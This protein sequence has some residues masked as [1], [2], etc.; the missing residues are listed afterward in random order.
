MISMEMLRKLAYP[1]QDE[2]LLTLLTPPMIGQQVI[3]DDK[4][5]QVIEYARFPEGRAWLIRAKQQEKE[6]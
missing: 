6:E 1:Q 4:T 2:K 3:Y 5:Y